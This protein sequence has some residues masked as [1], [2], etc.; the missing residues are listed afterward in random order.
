MHEIVLCGNDHEL[1]NRKTGSLC[2]DFLILRCG[3]ELFFL[4]AVTWQRQVCLIGFVT[5]ATEPS[6]ICSSYTFKIHGREWMIPFGWMSPFHN[7]T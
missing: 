1:N 4:V 3:G 5:G 7:F 2:V 6:T